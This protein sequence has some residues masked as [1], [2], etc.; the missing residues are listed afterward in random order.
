MVLKTIEHTI[1]GDGNCQ[2]NA[3]GFIL[4]Q[5]VLEHLKK[6]I[7]VC[8]KKL[9]HMVGQATKNASADE[10]IS[11]KMHL[12]DAYPKYT[13]IIT[14]ATNDD[15]KRLAKQMYTDLG[16]WGDEYSLQKMSDLTIGHCLNVGYIVLDANYKYLFDTITSKTNIVGFLKY[17][18]RHY[19]VYGFYDTTVGKEI[20]SFELLRPITRKLLKY[21]VPKQRYEHF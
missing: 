21:L 14:K 13:D 6:R 8:A 11:L 19:D 3:I 2:Y 5:I 7:K 16:S 9:R 10:I 15:I 1:P 18:S 17:N 4:E 20:W 12:S